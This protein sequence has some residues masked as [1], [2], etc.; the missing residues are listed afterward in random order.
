MP[1]ILPMF[2]KRPFAP[3]PTAE[4]KSF[5]L[6]FTFLNKSPTSVPLSAATLSSLDL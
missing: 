5:P 2:E 6:P 3:W 1:K 4:N